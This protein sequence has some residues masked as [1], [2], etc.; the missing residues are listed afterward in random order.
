ML[1]ARATIH[2]V[3][4]LGDDPRA[5]FE[6]TTYPLALI[7]SRRIAPPGHSI[8]LG[9]DATAPRYRQ[10]LWQDMPAWPLASPEAQRIAARMARDHPRLRE[11]ITPQLGVKTGANAVFL[12][13]PEALK[14][15][16]RP[17]IR[18]RDIRPFAAHPGIHAALARG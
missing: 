13:P 10:S 8:T 1:G 4:D 7:A 16:C 11:Q 15:W 18:G 5:G 12:D 17:A 14:A 6:A 3:A 2:R 9:L